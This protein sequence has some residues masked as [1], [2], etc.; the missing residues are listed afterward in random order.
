MIRFVCFLLLLPL[1]FVSDSPA[2]TPSAGI[3]AGDGAHRISVPLPGGGVDEVW[4]Y[5]AS[6]PGEAARLPVVVYGHGLN[7]ELANCAPDAGPGGIDSFGAHSFGSPRM[8]DVLAGA[9]YL[10]VTVLYRNKGNGAPGV[11][12][13]RPRDHYVRDARALLA[14]ARWARDRHGRGSGRVAFVGHSMG[15]W[16]AFWAVTNR[17]DLADLQ[18][19][20]DIR[21]VVLQAETANHITNVS[22][23]ECSQ[24]KQPNLGPYWGVTFIA[25]QSPDGVLRAGDLTGDGPVAALFAASYTELGLELLRT[26]FFTPA[27]VDIEGCAE[28]AGLP[29]SCDNRCVFETVK[30]RYGGDPLPPAK[31]LYR[32]PLLEADQAL[33]D[34]G[35]DAADP[36]AELGNPFLAVMRNTSP[37]Y[38][39]EGLVTGRALPLLARGDEH[40]DEAALRR[41][42]D[43]LAALGAE[44]PDPPLHLGTECSHG[45]YWSTDKPQC[46]LDAT[47]AELVAAFT[48]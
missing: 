24:G 30:R 28:L 4:I 34:L 40:Y 35:A 10:G 11:G 32:R 48:D 12:V 39:A 27:D 8:A 29:P 1:A 38:A 47:L 42:T 17:V 2:G 15:T 36:G 9:G 25:A 19:G 20:L 16:P 43:K 21:T 14:A 26:A 45:S 7:N 13:L 3:P 44:V 5:A 6:P 33:C 31:D 23:P 41:L 46:G 18:V 37:A 22:Q